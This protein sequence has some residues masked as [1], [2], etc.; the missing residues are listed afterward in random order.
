[1]THQP[2][3]SPFQFTQ[4]QDGSMGLEGFP[5]IRLATVEGQGHVAG[6]D[7]R[8]ELGLPTYYEQWEEIAR[9]RSNDLSG[10][11]VQFVLIDE[12]QPRV[13]GQQPYRAKAVRI[14]QAVQLEM[15]HA[16]FVVGLVHTFLPAFD[17]LRYALPRALGIEMP[18]DLS[19]QGDFVIATA[20][21]LDSPLAE[22][23]WE[24]LTRGIF[25]HVCPVIFLPDGEPE[26]GGELVQVSLVPADMPG[27]QNARVLKTWE[28]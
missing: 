11:H 10:R 24:G 1:M 6:R 20:T 4:D 2:H 15:G 12:S 7:W 19:P 17:E 14:Q 18:A 28:S 27:I 16:G 25:T 3:I 8:T 13:R 23:A 21:L 22:K 26:G 5:H 9:V